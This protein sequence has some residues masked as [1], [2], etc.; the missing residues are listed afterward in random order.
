MCQIYLFTTSV[1]WHHDQRYYFELSSSCSCKFNLMYRGLWDLTIYQWLLET[2]CKIFLPL[3]TVI[4]WCY[5]FTEIHSDQSCLF[6]YERQCQS[7]IIWLISSIQCNMV[8]CSKYNN[9]PFIF[10]LLLFGRKIVPRLI[11]NWFCSLV[12]SLCR[13]MV[14]IFWWN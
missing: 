12:I 8:E 1:K 9:F 11:I 13:Y 7:K 6:I 10:L 4:E 14:N 3:F 5:C 2:V